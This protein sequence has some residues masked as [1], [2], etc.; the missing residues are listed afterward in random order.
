[1][2]S[3]RALALLFSFVCAVSLG[4][5]NVERRRQ[6]EQLA[7]SLHAPA[8]LLC[9]ERPKEG[10]GCFGDCPIWNRAERG[11]AV[12]AAGEV[13]AQIPTFADPATEALLADVREAGKRAKS[14]LGDACAVKV[15][16]AGSPSPEI[17]AC[18][19]R[20][21]ARSADESAF[22]TAF[23]TLSV[24]TKKRTGVF[25]PRPWKPCFAEE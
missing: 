5:C 9:A 8:M 2:S 6:H 10:G 11:V 1:M 21:L 19:E 3:T 12:V 14:A 20:V 4:A 23:E 24:E 17:R 22:V 16:R 7:Q 15:D 18:A 13:V 25:L